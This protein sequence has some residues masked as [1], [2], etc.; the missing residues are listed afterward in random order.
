[1]NKENCILYFTL[2]PESEI[3]RKRISRSRR[4]NYKLIHKMY[5]HTKDVLSA[6]NIDIIEV[7]EAEQKGIGFGTRLSHAVE[8]VFLQGYQ[9]IIVVG[10]DCIDLRQEDLLNAQAQL[11]I[12]H[13]TI[14]QTK[15]GGV[16]LFT[17]SKDTFH[18]DSFRGL[19][20][21]QNTLSS[22]LYQWMSTTTSIYFLDI[23][24]DI[25]TSE[26]LNTWIASTRRHLGLY[27]Q[28]LISYIYPTTHVGL[29]SKW[30]YY[31]KLLP[32]RAPPLSFI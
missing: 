7:N 9:N 4:A 24:T 22:E 29:L 28:N 2:T 11:E 14:G 6:S 17:L 10:N 25:N 5:A 20:W 3:D 13:H 8:Q 31:S 27:F 12:G 16:Y 18:A 19:S 32:L 15:N 30:A 26:N 21:C 1:V 23:K